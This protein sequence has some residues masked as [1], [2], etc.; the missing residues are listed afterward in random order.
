MTD[1]NKYSTFVMM[2]CCDDLDRE[3]GNLKNAAEIEDMCKK[4]GWIPV[5]MKNDWKTI[6]GEGVTPKNSMR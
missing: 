5:S 1:S 4:S 2:L 6:C 3:N